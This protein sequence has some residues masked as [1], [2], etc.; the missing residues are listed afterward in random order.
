MAASQTTS[1]SLAK[2]MSAHSFKSVIFD[3]LVSRWFGWFCVPVAR[4]NATSPHRL[5]SF[6]IYFA[7][8]IKNPKICSFIESGLSS[9]GQF[10]SGHSGRLIL[11]SP[12][13]RQNRRTDLTQYIYIQIARVYT[14]ISLWF[15]C[16]NPVAPRA[17]TKSRSHTKPFT[18]D[19][20]YVGLRRD[21]I[22]EYNISR[23]KSVASHKLWHYKSAR[24]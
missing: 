16:E 5:P 22:Q 23:K 6:I 24:I 20:M 14:L 18:F 8:I 1:R 19:R 17:F 13:P 12:L 2:W 10:E 4:N 7:W 15:A 11:L 21:D 3:L 9:V